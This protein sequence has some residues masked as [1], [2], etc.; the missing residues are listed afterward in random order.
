MPPYF[1]TP[2]F[3]LSRLPL[4]TKIAL[5]GFS[6]IIS[7]AI[8]FVG[9]VLF[10]ERTGWDVNRTQ[11]NFIGTDKYH[12]D[13]PGPIDRKQET[14]ADKTERQINDII[15]PHSFMMPII[16]FVLCH[17][18]EMTTMSGLL[19][20]FMYL[21]S[22]ISMAIVI[23]SPYLIYKNKDFAYIAIPAMAAMLIIFLIMSLN[24]IINAWFIRPQNPP[25]SPAK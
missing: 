4:T 24:A 19:K 2:Y 23:F 20:L 11:I 10:T 14:V 5:T 7:S 9:L 13:H 3:H 8:L 21:F 6:V 22:C 1:A 25:A 18:T 16:F 17:L 12:K 15:H